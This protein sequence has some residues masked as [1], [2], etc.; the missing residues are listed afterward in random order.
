MH[1]EEGHIYHIYNRSNRKVFPGRENY[2][3]FLNKVHKHIEPCCEILAWCLMPNH[4]HFL[5]QATG[6]SIGDINEKHRLQTQLLSK[7][8]GVLLSSYT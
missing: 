5:L 8:W 2:L 7:N 6:K 4:F 1:F 3:F